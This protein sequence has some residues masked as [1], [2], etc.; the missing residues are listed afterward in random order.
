MHSSYVSRILS[1]QGVIVGIHIILSMVANMT[2][3]IGDSVV[4][5]I[6]NLV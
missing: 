1:C 5:S 6:F 4:D 2:E 3:E